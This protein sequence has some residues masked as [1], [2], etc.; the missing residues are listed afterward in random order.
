M[1]KR[2]LILISF[3]L[4]LCGCQKM[5]TRMQGKFYTDTVDGM[6]YLELLASDGCVAYFSGAEEDGGYWHIL[7]D[8]VI[9]VT[10][11]PEI[12]KSSSIIQ[13]WISGNGKI[14]DANTFSVPATRSRYSW[15]TDKEEKILYFK[16]R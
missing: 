7:D 13:Y 11:S 3:I 6:L 16:R 5:E 12:K 14:I 9:S 4:L 10:V 8:D 1:M 15:T 2:S